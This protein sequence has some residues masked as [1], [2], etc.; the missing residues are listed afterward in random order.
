MLD[1]GNDKKDH[2]GGGNNTSS[3]VDKNLAK[4]KK[5]KAQMNAVWK[6]IEKKAKAKERKEAGKNPEKRAAAK[7]D[8]AFRIILPIFIIENVALLVLL[9]TVLLGFVAIGAK[10]PA[11]KTANIYNVCGSDIVTEY[12]QIYLQ[13][14]ADD[15]SEKLQSLVDKVSDDANFTDDATCQYIAF[16]SYLANDDYSSAKKA[17]DNFVRLNEQGVNPSNSLSGTMSTENMKE[18]YEQASSI[19]ESGETPLGVG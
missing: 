1:S 18:Y 10:Q 8:L 4:D 2:L 6:R 13:P 5:Q 17:L 19:H 9:V 3:H 12:N 7:R 11:A 16:E 14:D 15:Y